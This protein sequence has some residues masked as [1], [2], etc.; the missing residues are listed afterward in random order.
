MTHDAGEMLDGGSRV[1]QRM[2][3]L[4]VDKLQSVFDSAQQSVCVRHGIRVTHVDVA[5]RRKCAQ[6]GERVRRSKLFVELT[7][8]QLQK[9]HCE[10]DVADAAG[11]V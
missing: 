10:L 3:L 6:C 11:T 2:D 7:V 5:R 4:F 9:L 1:G 8:H